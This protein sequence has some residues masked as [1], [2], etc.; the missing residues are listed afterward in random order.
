MIDAHI[1]ADT[2]PYEDFES[3]VISGVNTAI[4]CAHDPLRMTS[5]EVVFDHFYRLM[6]NDVKRAAENGLKLYLALG[7]HPRSISSDHEKILKKLPRLMEEDSVVAIGEIGL[8]SGS[9][10]EISIFK[11]QLEIADDLKARVIVHT[12]RSNKKEVSLKTISLIQDNINPTHAV[13]DHIDF[14]IVDDVI[15]EE[16]ML[17][18]TVQPE[19]MTPQE[20]IEIL[21]DY[22]SEKFLLNSDISS[23]PSDPLAVAKTVHLMKL[24]NFGNKEINQ[25]SYENAANFFSI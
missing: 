19:K 11:K 4:S 21:D 3:M 23:S 20:A 12:P 5:S 15:E 25:V 24:K 6:N 13:L 2:R 9:E 8:E 16:F 14:S 22:G 10:E 17:G 18:L 7:I 1:H